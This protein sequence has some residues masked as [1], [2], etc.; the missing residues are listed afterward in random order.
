ML[1]KFRVLAIILIAFFTL[2]FL[3]VANKVRTQLYTKEMPL[4]EAEKKAALG[5]PDAQ[6]NLAKAYYEGKKVPKNYEKAFELMQK[7]ADGG[8]ADAMFDLGTFYFEGIG[9]KSDNVKAR[10]WKQRSAQATR[11]KIAEL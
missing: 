10:Q 1:N 2:S 3:F 8:N 7:S 6:Y 11:R 4:E 9:V 5:N